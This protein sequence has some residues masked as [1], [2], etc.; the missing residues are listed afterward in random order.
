MADGAAGPLLLAAPQMLP[1]FEWD[2]LNPLTVLANAAA[3]TLTSGWQSFMTAIWAGG[4]WLTGFAFKI[5]DAFTTPD[6]SE[7]GLMNAIYPA[8]FAIGGALA[9]ILAFVQVGVAAWQRDGKGLAR[10]LVGIAQFALAWGGMLGVGAALTAATAGLTQGILQVALGVPSFAQVDL[11]RSWQPRDGVDAAVATVLG[12]C[13]VLLVFA[14]IG[15]LLIMLVRAGA[16]VILMAT[17]PISAAGL[18]SEGT[19]AWFWK[20]L[21]WFVAA[22]MIAP[23]SAL[24]LGVGKKL[25]DGVLSGAGASTEAAVGQAVIGT[26]LVVI[27]AFCPLILFRLLAF[28]D[29]GTS[30]GASFRASLD[31]AG[32]I[33]GLLGSGPGPAGGS[34]AATAQSGDGT[35]QGEANA[36]GATRAGWPRRWAR[37]GPRPKDCPRPGKPPPTY[38]ADILGAAGVG[39]QQPY[40]GSP[41]V[42]R[43]PAAGQN[44]PHG[45]AATTRG[46]RSPDGPDDPDPGGASSAAGQA[47]PVIPPP[48]PGS[49]AP[50]GSGPGSGPQS[51]AGGKGGGSGGGAGPAGGAGAAGAGASTAPQ[52]RRP[53]NGHRSGREHMS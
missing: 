51:G 10:L 52:P 50:A 22:L 42:Q 32:G 43:Q 2:E 46:R 29:P 48:T 31:A 44:Q 27:S 7:G 5:V 13:G 26:V 40:F 4:L 30:S 39:H 47:P 12:I 18:L 21:R 35:S 1:A 49:L 9:L 38:S 23:L 24:V 41:P 19:R 37:S 34:G 20:S 53:C 16:L 25:T 6:V 15:Y 36:G 3:V 14:A 17:S 8:T 11:L 33:A 28:V 45:T